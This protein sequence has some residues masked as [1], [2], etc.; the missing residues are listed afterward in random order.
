MALGEPTQ[1]QIPR[2]GAP[3]ATTAGGDCWTPMAAGPSRRKRCARRGAL[4]DGNVI[5]VRRDERWQFVDPQGRA[6]SKQRYGDRVALL[7]PGAWLV[8][9]E[10]NA[11]AILLDADLRPMRSFRQDYA[12][13]EKREGWT[14]LSDDEAIL[15]VDPAGRLSILSLPQGRVDIQ[16]GRAWVYARTSDARRCGGR[17]GDGRS[18][19]RHPRRHR[20]LAGRRQHLARRA[21]VPRTA[22]KR[23][24]RNAEQGAAADGAGRPRASRTRRP[25]AAAG[26]SAARSSAVAD[27]RRP[28][29]SC[30]SPPRT[31]RAGA[32]RHAGRGASRRCRARGGGRGAGSRPCRGCRRRGN[33]SRGSGGSRRPRPTLP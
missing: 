19:G 15:L 16:N 4:R 9:R 12:W 28:W 31:C 29:S 27:R 14:V 8:K 25:D 17:R 23:N 30:P 32:D 10:H 6:L 24:D 22:R 18:G 11:P 7:A 20:R 3:R 2:S 5:A 1:G 13:P 21:A 26:L 33:S